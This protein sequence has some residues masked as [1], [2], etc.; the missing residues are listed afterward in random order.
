MAWRLRSAAWTV[1]PTGPA[2]P[3]RDVDGWTRAG[4]ACPGES[5]PLTRG[6]GRSPH[7]S[8]DSPHRAG[9]LTHG[10]GFLTHG[11][12]PWPH[13]SAAVTRGS[14][15]LP[16]GSNVPT[17]GA[18]RSRPGSDRSLHGAETHESGRTGFRIAWQGSRGGAPERIRTSAPELSQ[19]G[20]TEPAS[21]V[22]KFNGFLALRQGH[23]GSCHDEKA[24]HPCGRA[25]AYGPCFTPFG[26]GIGL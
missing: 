26:S 21:I 24:A 2:P 7:G 15:C 14:T 3:T 13:G 12:T 16:R 9:P 17:R 4:N 23:S 6:P 1:G 22:V 19:E 8:T 11:S 10:A 25:W 20:S 18:N 5:G